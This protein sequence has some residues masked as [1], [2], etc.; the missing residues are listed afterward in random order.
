MCQPCT[1]D[2]VEP[3]GVESLQLQWGWGGSGRGSPTPHPAA[4]LGILQKPWAPGSRVT[5]NGLD[6]RDSLPQPDINAFCG[7]VLNF[8][9]PGFTLQS[10]KFQPKLATAGP[11]R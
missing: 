1:A 11:L 5:A 10:P 8:G 6:M 7:W 2:G 9:F 3:R 4:D